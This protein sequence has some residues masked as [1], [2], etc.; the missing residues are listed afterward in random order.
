M[1]HLL[2]TEKTLLPTAR[3]VGLYLL[4]ETD[5]K[6]SAEIAEALGVGV[7]TVARSL[8]SLAELGWVRSLHGLWT[9]CAPRPWESDEDGTW[10]GDEG[11]S[12]KVQERRSPLRGLLSLLDDDLADF[13]RTGL[14]FVLD[15]DGFV[16]CPAVA[17]DKARLVLMLE[18]HLRA[19]QA[20]REGPC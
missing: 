11:Y 12:P 8:K 18:D 6:T 5:P 19:L 16:I 4:G 1:K 9:S 2:V 20:A 17:T 15:E 7:S 13:V 14:E 3:I 10:A